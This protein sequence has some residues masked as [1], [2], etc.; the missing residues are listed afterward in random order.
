MNLRSLLWSNAVIFLAA[1][2]GRRDRTG[3][4]GHG[5]SR[6]EMAAFAL[7]I[8]AA[9]WCATAGNA[10]SSPPGP[11]CVRTSSLA[12]AA[13]PPEIA[14]HRRW[15]APLGLLPVGLTAWESRHQDVPLWLGIIALA[16]G[17]TAAVR[18]A[19]P[20]RVPP[21]PAPPARTQDDLDWPDLVH[22][23]H[24]A[25]LDMAFCWVKKPSFIRGGWPWSASCH[26]RPD[27]ALTGT[28]MGF[29]RMRT[30]PQL[31]R[32]QRHP[33][34]ALAF[35][36]AAMGVRWCTSLRRRPWRLGWVPMAWAVSLA[37]EER[38]AGYY[39]GLDALL[40]VDAA[41]LS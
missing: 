18:W 28:G 10:M 12:T 21:S 41:W 32:T 24:L 1:A 38:S 25:L 29:P 16:A 6:L 4:V 2:G 33:G 37:H 19:R 3:T 11:G 36:A 23:R 30:W 17:V 9:T 22:H 27:P 34:L 40:L 20:C 15:I 39:V 8:S 35:V 13:Q 7:G 14:L 5:G 26:R 31:A